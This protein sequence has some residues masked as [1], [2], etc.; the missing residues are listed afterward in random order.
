MVSKIKIHKVASFKNLA[1]IES[2]KKVNL[3]YGLNGT[4]KSTISNLFYKPSHFNF[5]DCSI[6][7]IE[8]VDVL[9]YNQTFIQEN[10]FETENLNGIFTL[11][12]ANK[13]A[14]LEITKSEKALEILEQQKAGSEIYK[15]ELKT[16]LD[17]KIN[18]AKSRIWEIKTKYS[19][20][21]RVLEF[22]L[23]GLKSDGT[24][25][26]AYL[27]SIKKGEN[28]PSSTIESVKEEV[29]SL[30]GDQAQKYEKIELTMPIPDNLEINPI[31]KK[32]IVGNN[33]SSVSEFIARLNNSDWILA[34]L[35]YLPD[36]INDENQMC[37]FCQEKT[38]SNRLI[39]SIKDYF[40]EEYENDVNNLKTALKKYSDA[41]SS[42]LDKTV[43]DENPKCESFKKDIELIFSEFSSIVSENIRL[44]EQKVQSPSI[45]ISL[46]STRPVFTKLAKIVEAVNG[47]VEEHNEK[48]ESKGKALS[49]LKNTF[50]QI[51]RW[52][53]DKTLSN[54][55][56]E[57]EAFDSK[58]LEIE[59][60]IDD[61]IKGIILHKNNILNQ[62]KKTINIEQA[63]TNINNSLVDL[64]IDGFSIVKHSDILYKIK[65]QDGDSKI[66]HSLSEGEKM[67]ISFLYFLELCRG[68]RNSTAVARKKIVVIDDP[69]SSLSHIYVFNIGRLILNE[70]L[71][72]SK[73]E[74]VFILT[75]SLYFFYELTDTKKERRDQNQKLFR[76][77]KNEN[78]SEI[79]V[80]KYE[81][82]Q[83]DYQSYW[84]IVNDK[85][86]P[87]ALIAN[88]M[89]NIIEYFYNFVEKSDLNV[90]FQKREMQEIR[91]QA[92]NRYINRESHSLGQ[93]I[94]D[95]KEFNYDH[96]REAF[97]NIFKISGYEDHYKKMAR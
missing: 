86:Q 62:Q 24:K 83:N 80:M 88:C 56:E 12:Q 73:Y 41:T 52:D 69:I 23:E 22:C 26:L 5:K 85:D 3:I 60:S 17:I 25:L 13:D 53:Y 74:Q 97:A 7:G 47:L 34:G 31:F 63:I 55:T 58:N 14:E 29:N 71:L 46:T 44:I 77:R 20:G 84:H 92:F 90:V 78:G 49:N 36:T 4:G 21:D 43:F 19:G 16:Q 9:V 59:K 30:I 8:D 57:K 48:I 93:N 65:R 91:F 15:M 27:E 96:F 64:G 10:F 18:N 72:S 11:S 87:P 94:F 1:L 33:N 38:I 35:N 54:L 66:F 75:H 42:V 28:R 39:N 6:E 67:I 79:L 61:L 50:W 89:R 70:F 51:N 68:R 32:Q 45:V 40:D 95:I 76:L 2:D 81:E 37:P 82:I